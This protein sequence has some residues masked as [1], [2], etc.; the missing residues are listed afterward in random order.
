MTIKSGVPLV[1]QTEMPSL[2]RTGW[3]KDVTLSEAVTNVAVTHGPFAAGGGGKAQPATT[4][5]EAIVTIGCPETK[6]V[7]IGTTGCAWPPCEHKTCAPS[8]TRKPG[9]SASA[10]GSC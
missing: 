5:G 9:I 7:G 4:Y 8:C 2:N 6:T 1:T 10:V 3:P